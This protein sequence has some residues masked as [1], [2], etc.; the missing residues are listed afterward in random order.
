MLYPILGLP[1]T[2][3]LEFIGIMTVIYLIAMGL[4]RLFGS[5]QP[6]REVYIIREYEVDED[7]EAQQQQE[8]LPEE[9]G[10]QTRQETLP[11][12]V[13]AIHRKKQ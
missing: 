10:S 1:N 8:P 5:K 4:A 3:M 13:V 6:K 11:D 9:Q 12:N 7:M 2:T